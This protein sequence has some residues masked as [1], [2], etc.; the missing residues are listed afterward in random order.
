MLERAPEPLDAGA[1]GRIFGQNIWR[2]EHGESLRFA[3]HFE[4]ILASYPSG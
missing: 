3:A 2:R 1:T 4:A